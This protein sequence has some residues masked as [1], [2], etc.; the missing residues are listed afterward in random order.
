MEDDDDDKDDEN[1]EENNDA[2]THPIKDDQQVTDHGDWLGATPGQN[3]S[4]N[5]GWGERQH[6][7]WTNQ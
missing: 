2:D 3:P 7:E 5:Q 4:D 6:T 1:E